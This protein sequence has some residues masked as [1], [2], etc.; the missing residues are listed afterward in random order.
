MNTNNFLD[1][2][3]RILKDIEN[4]DKWNLWALINISSRCDLMG[5]DCGSFENYAEQ[6]QMNALNIVLLT[7]LFLPRILASK[8]K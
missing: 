6:M 2:A 1:V 7:R 5:V 4:D 8:G 3:K